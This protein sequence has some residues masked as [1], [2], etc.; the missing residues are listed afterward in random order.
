MKNR[1]KFFTIILCLMMLFNSITVLAN[2]ES[3]LEISNIAET[4]P[5]NAPDTFTVHG[6]MDMNIQNTI[7][8]IHNPTNLNKNYWTG[9]KILIGNNTLSDASKYFT[10]QVLD[11]NTWIDGKESILINTEDVLNYSTIS[12]VNKETNSILWDDSSLKEY[13]DNDFKENFSAIELSALIS[14]P[15]TFSLLTEQDINNEKYG[16]TES[17]KIKM[18]YIG[19]EQWDKES[20]WLKDTQDDKVKYINKN[21]FVVT[22]AINELT[23]ETIGFSPACY[24]NKNEIKFM[25][26]TAMQKDIEFQLIADET[27][28][29]DSWT[30]VLQDGDGF[31][32]SF[33]KTFDEEN[34]I[35]IKVTDD[36]IG[37]QPYTQTSAVVTNKN[38]TIIAYGKIGDTT[39]GI[40]TIQ[41]P[42][43]DND[44]Y[45]IHVFQES[46]NEF[47]Q[48][49]YISNIISKQY[50]NQKAV[51]GQKN[52]YVIQN[53]D[54]TFTYY[55]D[56]Y[57]KTNTLENTML[58][59]GSYSKIYTSVNPV[60]EL[61]ATLPHLL[62]SGENATLQITN[63]GDYDSIYIAFL[64]QNNSV[65]A[66][67]KI[68]DGTIGEKTFTVPYTL[69]NGNTYQIQIFA[70]NTQTKNASNFICDTYVLGEE[71]VQPVQPIIT[72]PPKSIKTEEQLKQELLPN[73]FSDPKHNSE[74]TIRWEWYKPLN[75]SSDAIAKGT[76]QT[77]GK[78]EEI[79][80]TGSALAYWNLL[81][82]NAILQAP[83]N[84]EIKVRTENQ[85]SFK[86]EV[87]QALD[88]RPDITLK[89]LYKHQ[90][91]W[92]HL[93]VQG[94]NLST[95]IVDNYIGF[96]YLNTICPVEAVTDWSLYQGY[97]ESK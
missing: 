89:I 86:A 85:I 24:L 10:F 67:G 3:L 43:L 63:N 65:M 15:N 20:Y 26:S 68:G 44:R 53:E 41:L 96:L 33:S 78:K 48:T 71:K 55:K 35:Y 54:N 70:I 72:E 22:R 27:T 76:C 8:S 45:T 75:A 19:N 69:N 38:G 66:F 82:T 58:G 40:K 23:T 36:A 84:S 94:G 50:V 80:I 77:C 32:A 6:L 97:I 95:H 61:T 74:H 88:S 2:E 9:S 25:K 34:K 14:S 51:S 79:T 59:Y 42:I 5:I 29:S 46:I 49:D 73:N 90:G 13:L 17:R 18:S 21:G 56:E 4:S 60:T 37:I 52:I 28:S 87:Y 64:N 92:Y 1:Y 11:A 57:T 91:V 47:G 93:T 83:L 39:K 16:Y 30:M 62:S 81:T 31:Q 7:H 12:H